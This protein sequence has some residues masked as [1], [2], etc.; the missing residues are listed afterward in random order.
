[1]REHDQRGR[2]TTTNRQLFTLPGG[3]LVIDSPGV[4]EIQLWDADEGLEAAFD[5]IDA[6]AA[7]CHFRDCR[8]GAEPGCA[9]QAAVAAGTLAGDRLASY[10]KL[11]R[12]ADAQASAEDA[13]LRR[14]KKAASRILAKLARSRIREKNR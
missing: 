11:V 5:D 9:V 10:H 8:H 4:R 2:H 7:D 3:G 14:K 13:V 12:E 6:L 1:V